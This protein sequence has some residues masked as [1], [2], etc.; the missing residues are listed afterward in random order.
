MRNPL[1]YIRII[2]TVAAIV[3]AVLFVQKVFLGG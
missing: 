3:L 1:L 2:V